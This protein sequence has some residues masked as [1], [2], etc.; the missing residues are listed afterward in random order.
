MLLL[1]PAL[2]FADHPIGIFGPTTGGPVVTPTAQTLPQGQWGVG[3]NGQYRRFDDRSR[4]QLLAQAGEEGHVHALDFL[5]SGS[6]AL[7]YGVRDD[8][9]FSLS[10]PYVR[11]ENIL[12]AHLHGD[13]GGGF[14][15]LG[16]A[17]GLGDAAAAV[18]WRPW[19][20]D[21]GLKT[22]LSVGI[23]LPTGEDDQL[24]AEGERL[25]TEFQPGSGAWRPFVGVITSWN[26]ERI[27]WH[28]NLR[29]TLANEGAQDTELG[30]KI[31]YGLAL[32]YRL[33]GADEEHAHGP[34]VSGHRHH[35]SSSLNWD[36]L[37]E[38]TGEYTHG[39]TID[40]ITED[41]FENIIYLAPG[42]RL[43]GIGG[44]TTALSLGVPV[45]EHRKEGHI[46]TDW[47]A[48]LSASFSY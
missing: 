9:T 48:V 4:R 3:V 1:L 14:H 33:N 8:L 10:L 25:E 19:E 38:F 16:D 15:E 47:R 21:T 36:A 11:R 44:W 22:A 27:A 40:G 12:E 20:S 42:L 34:G 46:D 6:V 39:Q 30:D 35:G 7:S 28:S 26:G 32:V 17:S 43:S 41:D 37:L 23:F 5:S 18:Y 31:D 2:T 29:Y 45:Y 13:H 24:N